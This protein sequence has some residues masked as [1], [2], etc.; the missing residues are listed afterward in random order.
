M[1]AGIVFVLV[2]LETRRGFRLVGSDER[3]RLMAPKLRAQRRL[4]LCLNAMAPVG[5]A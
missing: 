3:M 4:R 5:V 1:G 2:G